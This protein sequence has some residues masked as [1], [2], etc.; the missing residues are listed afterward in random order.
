M[1]T[2]Y[3]HDFLFYEYMLL[4]V[5]TRTLRFIVLGSSSLTALRPANPHREGGVYFCRV[6]LPISMFTPH[7]S[8]TRPNS[9]TS[10]SAQ[11]CSWLLARYGRD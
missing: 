1:Q 3:A 10:Q 11:A 6:H 5:A 8:P 9:L 7:I 4:P 2:L